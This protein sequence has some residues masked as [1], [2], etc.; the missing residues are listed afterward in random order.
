M[1]LEGMHQIARI[2][3]QKCIFSVSQGHIPLRHPLPL[4]SS[5]ANDFYSSGKGIK[6]RQLGGKD[7]NQ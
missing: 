6:T 3:F 4:F 2:K 5:M 1:L 7:N